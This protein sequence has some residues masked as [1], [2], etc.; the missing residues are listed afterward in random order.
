MVNMSA[1]A[2]SDAE[3]LDL[4]LSPIVNNGQVVSPLD[5]AM[6]EEML[7]SGTLPQ[8]DREGRPVI[9]FDQYLRLRKKADLSKYSLWMER[10]DQRGAWMMQ[11]SKYRKH[12]TRGYEGVG[13]PESHRHTIEELIQLGMQ[14]QAANA[15]VANRIKPSKVIQAEPRSVEGLVLFYCKDKYPDCKRVFDNPRGLKLHWGKDHG[16]NPSLARKRKTE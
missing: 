14:P 9:S 1:R 6:V 11:A 2:L 16:E 13:A 8:T 10:P 12:F 3:V 4:G 7:R 15:A 5:N